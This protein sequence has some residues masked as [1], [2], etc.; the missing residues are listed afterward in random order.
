MYFRYVISRCSSRSSSRPDTVAR[1]PTR[2]ARELGRTADQV[3]LELAIV[4][5]VGLALPRFAR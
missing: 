5:D 3:R 4:L 1:P 2:T